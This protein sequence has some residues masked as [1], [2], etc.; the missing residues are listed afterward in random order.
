MRKAYQ[1]PQI[2]FE[3]FELSDNI[4]ACEL[5]SSNQAR[6][7]CPVIDKTVVGAEWTIFQSA[8]NGCMQT[9]AD[10]ASFCYEIPTED[11]NVYIS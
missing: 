3:N 10:G 1:K 6:Y 8:A 5:I 7:S 11:Y 2:F 9:P 4:A